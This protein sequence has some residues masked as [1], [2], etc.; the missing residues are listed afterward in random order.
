M[1][2]SKAKY[3]EIQKEHSDLQ[4]SLQDELDESTS[5]GGALNSYK[6]AATYRLSLEAK[7]TRV[8]MLEE[9]LKEAEIL[10]DKVEG[11][12]I[13]IGKEFTLRSAAGEK[14]YRLVSSAEADPASGNIS[15]VSPL[16]KMLLN[17]RAGE[18]FDFNG[19][20]YRIAALN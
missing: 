4:K 6:E 18:E 2:I 7:H 10:P 16:G 5:R 8:N 1:Q 17:K 15:D 20:K 9:I 11:D 13:R 3:L 12:T 14:N 19:T